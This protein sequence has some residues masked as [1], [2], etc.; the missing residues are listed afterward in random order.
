MPTLYTSVSDY[1]HHHQRGWSREDRLRI[2]LRSSTSRQVHFL[3]QDIP[4]T[5]MTSLRGRA[6]VGQ[7][8]AQAP[9][10][11]G[12]I[13]QHGV[14][15]YKLGRPQTIAKRPPRRIHPRCLR[16][17]LTTSVYSKS[18]TQA[19]RRLILAATT[20]SGAKVRPLEPL[21]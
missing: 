2:R 11:I 5:R 20:R 12:N 13:Q 19:H 3:P 10:G 15:E 4:G 14:P 21:L 8:P 16:R 7:P 17:S 18:R 6:Y 9:V 1:S